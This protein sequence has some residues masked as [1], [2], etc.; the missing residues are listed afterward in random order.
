[1]RKDTY[2]CMR[3]IKLAGIASLLAASA[4][5][6]TTEALVQ[7]QP[8]TLDGAPVCAVDM[9]DYA[10]SSAGGAIQCP[11]GVTSTGK[12]LLCQASFA[13][14]VADA[15]LFF[16]TQ[17]PSAPTYLITIP[18]GAF[19]LS[20]ETA[21]LAGLHGAI[22]VSGIAPSGAGCLAGGAASTGV[23]ALS[24]NPCLVISGAGAGATTLTT[25]NGNPAIFGK[26]VSHVMFENMTMAQPDMSATQG[27]FVSQGTASFKGVAYPTLTLD[28]APGFP[29]PLALYAI[30]CAANG[31]GGCSK[32]ALSTM[33]GGL[34]VRAFT[35]TAAPQLIMSTAA[36]DSNAQ[37]PFGYPGLNG[38]AYAAVAPSQPEPA[39]FPNRWTITLSEPAS[40][41]AVPSYYSAT[42]GGKPN[43][44]CMKTDDAQAFWFDDIGGRGSDVIMN[45][46]EWVGA[47]RGSF[48]GV[49]GALSGG[50]LG[51]Q[52]YNSSIER[53]PPILGQAQCLS[54][55]SGGLQFGQPTDPPIYGNLVYGLKS[56]GTGDDSVAMFNDIGGTRTPTGGYYPQ[57]VIAQSMIGN[58]FARDILLTNDRHYSGL[59]GKSPVFVDAFTQGQI[60]DDG[61][62]DPLVLGNG[63]CPVTYVNY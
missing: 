26:N 43:L 22:D 55:Q 19:D 10:S 60:S 46:M 50:G 35:N 59:E 44:L 30:N 40:G 1:M 7:C 52:V 11:S 23:V 12:A 29:T 3:A 17:G 16:K 27:V 45:N 47:A 58:S 62:C 14:A 24:G 4:S 6:K 38:S 31:A 18:G 8:S 32:A 34:Y 15:A 53:G 33:A 41:H 49:N 37:V 21:T 56:Q 61:N 39:E 13:A 42:T 36:V 57:T 54:T 48:R 25:A 28:I 20:S 51:A 5:A 9:A 2:T 63:N